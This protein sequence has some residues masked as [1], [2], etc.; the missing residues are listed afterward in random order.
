MI[1]WRELSLR[2]ADVSKKR[3]F[4]ENKC[5]AGKTYGTKCAAGKIFFDWI[6]MGSLS[7]WFSMQFINSGPKIPRF[8]HCFKS[9]TQHSNRR[10]PLWLT[11]NNQH[12]RKEGPIAETWRRWHLY[13]SR[14]V[15]LALEFLSVVFYNRV[16]TV[17]SSSGVE[18]VN[19]DDCFYYFKPEVI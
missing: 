14:R 10:A 1:F 18:N 6:L 19:A 2:C 15:L 13:I 17:S 8:L 16:K 4:G 3:L 5:A 7:C 11:W 12:W 9:K